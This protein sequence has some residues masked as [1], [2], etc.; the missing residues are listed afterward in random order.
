MSSP[1]R[2]LFVRDQ[3]LA[4]LRQCNGMLLME[5]TLMAQINL[6]IAPPA[7]PSEIE[8]ALDQLNRKGRVDFEVD[9]DDHRIK[10]WK[11]VSK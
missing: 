5:A 10:R 11:I 2:E 9:Q 6:T 3:V 7:T 4:V 8:R 1:V